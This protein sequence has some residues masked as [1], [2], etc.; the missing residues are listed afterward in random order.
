MVI[1]NDVDA[2]LAENE[3][4]SPPQ[5]D[6]HDRPPLRKIKRKEMTESMDIQLETDMALIAANMELY[7]CFEDRCS[8]LCFV[9]VSMSLFCPA[10]RNRESHMVSMVSMSPCQPL[11]NRKQENQNNQTPPHTFP[12]TSPHTTPPLKNLP[13]PPKHLPQLPH[14]ARGPGPMT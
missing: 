5:N 7:D 2:A 8:C 11:K 12:H 3:K 13:T 9:L 4:A 10:L 1:E 14:T 6:I